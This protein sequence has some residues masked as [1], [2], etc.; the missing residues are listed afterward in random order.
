MLFEGQEFLENGWFRDDVAVD[1][2]KLETFKGINRLYHDLIHLRRNLYG[3]T[4]GLTG[5]FVNVHHVNHED[6]ILAF[7]RW[8]EGGPQDDVI[9]V[10][11][12]TNRVLDGDYR[13]GFP[14]GGRW[15]IRFNSD[16]TGYS[17]DFHN[18]SNPDGHVMAEKEARDNCE[19]SG[20]VALPS[21]GL[22]ILSQEEAEVP[23]ENPKP[24]KQGP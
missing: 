24:Q 10:A 5:P 15:T 11:S 12:F 18:V 4:K 13:I 6:K 20:I 17:E 23:T 8:A 14:R 19:Y 9:V 16:W 1:W 3:I 2:N 7:H 22:L 21:Y